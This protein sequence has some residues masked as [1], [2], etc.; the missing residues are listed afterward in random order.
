MGPASGVRVVSLIR[1]PGGRP[2]WVVRL[3]DLAV[4]VLLLLGVVAATLGA[5]TTARLGEPSQTVL[6]F[7]QSVAAYHLLALGAC[8]W[9]ACAVWQAWVL[10]AL[11]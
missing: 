8:W 11:M 2:D 5:G 1:I 10:L 7:A 3:R 4:L 6:P 9:L